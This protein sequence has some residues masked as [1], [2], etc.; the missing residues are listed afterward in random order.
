M[1]AAAATP[2]NAEVLQ[3]MLPYF[4]T[5]FGNAESVHNFGRDA[6]KSVENAK[7]QVAK[8]I[9]AD[10]SEIHFT[11]GA[12]EANRWV[13][14][15]MVRNSESHRVIVSAIEHPS[16]HELCMKLRK[17]GYT[18]D[19]IEVD[20]NGVVSMSDLVAKLSK[21]AALVSVITANH[22]VGTIQYVHTIAQMCRKY[23]V[24]FH[25]DASLAIGSVHI[26]VKEM[27]IDALSLSSHKIYGPKGVGA[28]YI[29]SGL[30]ISKVQSGTLNVPGI[31]GFG[32][33]VEITMRDASTN[34]SRLKAL[35]DYMVRE[36]ES[37][38]DYIYLNG[39]KTQR[40][41]NNINLSFSGI[42]SEMMLVTLD[43]E[44]ITVGTGAD[45]SPTLD[46]MH[47]PPELSRS[48]IRFTLLRGTTKD[49]IDFV[50]TKLQKLVKKLRSLSGVSVYKR[51]L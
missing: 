50:I 34:N 36:I 41:P 30:P 45:L 44:G 42:P 22:E 5:E 46:A 17:D 21:P 47:T 8:A 48:A 38:F 32:N 11:S 29:R 28:L 16:I 12:T 15:G 19:F 51:G 10:P 9:N 24:P 49:D 13:I 39:S 37:K 14:N 18:V 1:D 25:T 26:D 31:V 35:R 3:G 23:G 20:R 7:K 27:Q 2:I 4:T 43:M 33:A 6:K 40:L